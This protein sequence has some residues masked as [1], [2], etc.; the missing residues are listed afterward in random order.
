MKI[1]KSSWHYRFLK[2]MDT[3]PH[4]YN[5]TLRYYRFT[6]V[7]TVLY[8]ITTGWFIEGI[9]HLVSMSKSEPVEYIDT[10]EEEP[11]KDKVE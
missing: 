3:D 8:L 7:L 11:L 4:P 1:K 5:L 9:R 10:T 6:F 2:W